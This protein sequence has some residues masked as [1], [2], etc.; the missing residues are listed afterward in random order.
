MTLALQRGLQKHWNKTMNYMIDTL[1]LNTGHSG[2]SGG[3][4]RQG[5]MG[6][7]TL[8]NTP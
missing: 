1:K 4:S 3:Y 2:A 5:E 8:S 7:A 6:L